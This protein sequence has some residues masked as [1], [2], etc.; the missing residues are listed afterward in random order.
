MTL[1]PFI[2]PE[3]FAIG[4]IY[5]ALHEGI[6]EADIA[7][8]GEQWQKLLP[9]GK[10]L[11]E[12]RLKGPPLPVADAVERTIDV[13]GIPMTSKPDREEKT[14]GGRPRPRDFKTSGWFGAHDDK[15]WDV[16]GQ[17]IG[18]MLGTNS[19][20]AVLDLVHKRTGE[21]KII[22]VDLTQ[23]KTDALLAMISDLA[24]NM[25]SRVEMLADI[26]FSGSGQDVPKATI[27]KAF[28]PRLSSCVSKYGPCPYYA[29]CWAKAGDPEKYMYKETGKRPWLD[30]M[31]KDLKDDVKTI[32]AMSKT[33]L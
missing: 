12:A 4:S 30:G 11:Y 28:P 21:T 19:Q 31:R 16:N 24:F 25:H 26:I 10:R 1:L 23:D 33:A 18:Q 13:P 7:S 22:T 14:F 5:H 15:F 8:W 6:S 3:Y 17:I 32:A 20:S 29:R 9:E 27:D 2:E